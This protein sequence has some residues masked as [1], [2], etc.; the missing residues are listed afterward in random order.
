MASR[1]IDNARGADRHGA[2]QRT[3]PRHRVA[4]KRASVRKHGTCAAEAS[5]EDLS[6]YGCRLASPSEH[7]AGERLWLRFLG[8]RAVAAS[9]VWAEHGLIGCRFDAPIERSLARFLTLDG[10]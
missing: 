5:L 7:V 10:R 4:M 8:G 2:E 6:I 3:A 1:A 9:V